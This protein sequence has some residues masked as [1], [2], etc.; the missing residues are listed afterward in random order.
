MRVL[1]IHNYYQYYGGEETYFF[2][3]KKLLEEKGH[4]VILY[5]KD[6]KNIKTV[7]DKVRVGIGMFWN[8]QVE[9]ELSKI[10]KEFKPDIAHFNNIYPLI[11]VTSYYVCK[12]YNI[13]IVQH[14]HNYRFM[15][16]KGI[17]FRNGK[18]CELCVRKNFPFYSI[19]FGCYHKSRAASLFF[20]LAF[21]FHKI[22]GAFNLIDKFIFPS[23]FTNN[24]YRKNLDVSKNKAIVIPYFV[25]IKTREIKNK[26]KK[27]YFLFVGRLSEEKGIV[28]LLEVFKT[29]PKLKLVVIGDGPLRKEVER[30]REYPNITILG[31]LSRDKVLL[32]IQQAK[33]I[34]ISS[35][36]YEISPFVYFEVV[37]QKIPL[38]MPDNL[39]YDKKNQGVYLYRFGDIDNL[40]KKIIQL[41]KLSKLKTTTKKG[42][43][44]NTIPKNY[45]YSNLIKLYNILH[46]E[47]RNNRY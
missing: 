32:Y 19:L 13:P 2:S 46:D 47:N 33:A 15:C 24:Y 5:T 29:L 12:K 41:S 6:S 35:L 40:K 8:W 25:D 45:H 9:K 39:D 34:I 42:E 18:I 36:W 21:F 28:Q 20:S 23:E 27:N 3:L 11:T 26:R 17:L 22:T 43:Q 38:L 44:K 4:K 31:F 1:L 7:W 14:I 16:P 10:I 37:A 30:Y